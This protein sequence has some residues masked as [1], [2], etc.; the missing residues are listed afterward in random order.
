M[1]G[2]LLALRSSNWRV[3]HA[4]SRNLSNLASVRVSSMFAWSQ[5]VQF[6]RWLFDRTFVRTRRFEFP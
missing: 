4:H 1:V 5:V 6:N 2:R 3:L